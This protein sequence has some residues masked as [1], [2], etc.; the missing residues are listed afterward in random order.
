[1]VPFGFGT[2]T[3]GSVIRPAAYCGVVGYK[4]SFGT[5][6]CAGMKHLSESLD[7]IGVIAR[8]VADCALLVHAVSGRTLPDLSVRDLKAPRI[9]FCRT[10]R[11]Q[12]SCDATHTI[13]EWCASRLEQRGA[14]VREVELPAAF[15]R[16]YDIQPV[17]SGHEAAR[18]MTPEWLAHKD[19]L[20][21]HMRG[22]VE[23][24]SARPRQEYSDAM[25]HA[26]DCRRT[27]TQALADAGVD[28]LL[29]PSA[30]GE[31]PQGLSS[32]GE[33]LFNRNWT[34]LGVPCMTLPAGSGPKGLPL[35]VQLVADYDEDERLL[36][37]A[38]WVRRA[39]AS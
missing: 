37:A 2:Q 14:S 24:Y 5:I 13:L 20:S 11:W 17:I 8:A 3:G 34:L 4:P 22:Q 35:G 33:A 25:R 15:D 18:A 6:N 29:T 7:T 21:E 12:K 9:G 30:P 31:A 27:F 23:T 32:T 10:S 1:M 19:L 36:C 26:R 38:E 39:L 16:L 28:V